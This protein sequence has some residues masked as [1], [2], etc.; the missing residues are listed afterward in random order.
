M[1]GLLKLKGAWEGSRRTKL[2]G[3]NLTGKIRSWKPKKTLYLKIDGGF[4]GAIR[5]KTCNKLTIEYWKRSRNLKDK[6][7]HQT[8]K[9]KHGK[10]VKPLNWKKIRI[11]GHFIEVQFEENCLRGKL[12]DEDKMLKNCIYNYCQASSP[13]QCKILHAHKL[14]FYNII[15]WSLSLQ[16]AHD[17]S[18]ITINYKSTTSIYWTSTLLLEVSWA[19]PNKNFNATKE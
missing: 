17:D 18:L 6:P 10:H 7:T 13:H 4:E 16:Y 15:T 8:T 2:R 3:K 9:R 14:L 19:K 5:H 1:L 12:D 11:V